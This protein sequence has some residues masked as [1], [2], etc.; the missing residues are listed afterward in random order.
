MKTLINSDKIGY[1]KWFL[2]VA[3]AVF[4]L[5]PFIGA[6]VLHADTGTADQ[7]GKPLEVV[8][9]EIREK[10][11][12][13]ADEAINPRKL[14][15]RDLEEV[16]EAVMSVMF[17]D[18]EQHEVMDE[19]MGGEGSRR[20]ARMHRRMGYNYL[21]GGGYG[22]MGGMMGGR[23][24]RMGRNTQRNYRQNDGGMKGGMM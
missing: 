12:V 2:Y 16:G 4:I 17:P 9:Q 19:M 5:S 7:H 1:Q 18:P 10:Y 14:S 22:M 23:R 6:M 3:A 21:S 15:D 11:G 13:H 8:L 20:L 24:G